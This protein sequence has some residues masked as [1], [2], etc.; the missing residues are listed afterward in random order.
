MTTLLDYSTSRPPISLLKAA[1]VTG[2]G[3]YIGW[4]SVPGFH[5]IGKNLTRAEAQRYLDAGI[6]IFLFFEYAPDA[7]AHGAG[8]GRADGNLAMSQLAQLGAP[9]DMAVYF[10]V[11]YDIPDFAPHLP[12]TPQNA[13]AKLGPVGDY[14]QT[15]NE[16]QHPFAVGGYG[17]YYAIKRLFDAGLIHF[18]C[19]TVAWSGGQRDPRAQ[20]YQIVATSPIAGADVDIREHTTTGSDYGQWPRP[21]VA[22]K[23]S[24]DPTAHPAPEEEPMA[25]VLDY[26]KQNAAV[27]LPVPAGKTK[28]VLYADPGFGTDHVTPHIRV[29]F[30]PKGGGFN[31]KPAQPSWDTPT[32]IDLGGSTKVTIGRLDEGDTAITVDFS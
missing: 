23:P 8:Q 31:Q 10:A 21:R 15:I 28:V 4:D 17:G 29:G 5:S 6:E 25:Y 18:G 1:G 27:V 16:L 13:R 20:V 14:F 26:L 12:D 9:P 7:P 3:R 11:D 2:V 19:Q 30:V 32:V 24:T 22:P